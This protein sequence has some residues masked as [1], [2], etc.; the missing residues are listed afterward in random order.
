MNPTDQ[1]DGLPILPTLEE[2]RRAAEMLATPIDFDQLVADGVLRRRGAWWEILDW[3][4]LPEHAEYKIQ[5][6]MTGNR[7][8]FCR[9]D[10]SLRDRL[11]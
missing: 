4:R 10:P 6:V 3:Q 11:K 5:N 9:H 8:Q 2:I 7:V 1:D